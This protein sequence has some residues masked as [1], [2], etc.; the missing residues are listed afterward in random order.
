MGTFS[1]I[2]LCLI[3]MMSPLLGSRSVTDDTHNFRLYAFVFEK[4]FHL[5]N[6]LCTDKQAAQKHDGMQSQISKIYR[7]NK[8]KGNFG[9]AVSTDA[10]G[11]GGGSSNREPP[12]YTAV[13]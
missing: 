11:R 10:R 9:W 2:S 6:T 13:S 12:L 1:F 8:S 7:K 3:A 4:W 5:H